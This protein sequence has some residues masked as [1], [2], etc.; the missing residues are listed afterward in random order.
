MLIPVP[1]NMCARCSKAQSEVPRDALTGC[2]ALYWI[3]Y[4]TIGFDH[5]V[6][7]FLLLLYDAKAPNCRKSK[8][9][10]GLGHYPSNT[11]LSAV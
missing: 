11:A 5:G 8:A 2:I 6:G 9:F 1:L 7:H 10:K 3:W 4:D